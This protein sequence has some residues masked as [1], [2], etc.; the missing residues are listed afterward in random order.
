[1]KIYIDNVKNKAENDEKEY[2]RVGKEV[3]EERERRREVEKEMEEG[4][5]RMEERHFKELKATEE[6]VRKEVAA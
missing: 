6:R 1:M 4:K 3:V 2:E 5:K